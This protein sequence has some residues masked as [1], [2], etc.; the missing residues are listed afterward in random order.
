MKTLRQLFTDFPFPHPSGLPETPISGIAIDSRKVQ[1]GNLFV[2]L[3]GGST[4]G[5]RYIP[6]AIHSGAAAIVG[7]QDMPGDGKTYRYRVRFTVDGEA[8]SKVKIRAPFIKLERKGG[9][10]YVDNVSLSRVGA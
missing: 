2:A 5:H 7:S 10:V 9:E 6:Q 4:D 8:G 3:Q 1:P